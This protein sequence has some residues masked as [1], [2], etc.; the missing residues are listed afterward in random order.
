VVNLPALVPELQYFV[1][2]VDPAGR[3]TTATPFRV[4]AGE[5][6]RLP[7]VAVPSDPTDTTGT[8]SEAPAPR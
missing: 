6:V 2:F 7:D 5:T 3:S 4:R 8:Q 1:R